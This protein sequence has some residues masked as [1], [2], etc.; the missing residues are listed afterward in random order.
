MIVFISL[1]WNEQLVKK[2]KYGYKSTTRKE[3]DKTKSC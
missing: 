2:G 1:N 3:N